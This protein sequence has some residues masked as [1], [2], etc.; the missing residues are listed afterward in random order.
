MEWINARETL[1]DQGQYFAG[2]DHEGNLTIGMFTG[3]FT[4]FP[5]LPPHA[6]I[7]EWVPIFFNEN[8]VFF[9]DGNPLRDELVYEMD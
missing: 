6:E 8:G 9:E 5:D 3:D 2:R 4:S 1:P 7:L